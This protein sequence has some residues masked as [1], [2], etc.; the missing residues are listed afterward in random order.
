MKELVPVKSVFYHQNQNKL[1]SLSREVTEERE[2][3]VIM[4]LRVGKQR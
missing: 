1:R 4:I 3:T 2:V